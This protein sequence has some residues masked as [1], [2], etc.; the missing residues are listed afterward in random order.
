MI[1][2]QPARRRISVW[3]ILAF[4][5]AMMYVLA[6]ACYTPQWKPVLWPMMCVCGWRAPLDLVQILS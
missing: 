1:E 2:G 5:L 3:A 6:V 4:I